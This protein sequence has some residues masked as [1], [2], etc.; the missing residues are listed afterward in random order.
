[1]VFKACIICTSPPLT[2]THTLND[3]LF[4]SDLLSTPPLTHRGLDASPACFE[5][6]PTLRHLHCLLPLPRPP[7]PHVSTWLTPPLP[8]DFCSVVT[9]SLRLSQT[10]L[11]HTIISL[12]HATRLLT[13]WPCSMTF[14]YINHFLTCHILY[15][16]IM[17]IHNQCLPQLEYQP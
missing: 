1:M 16:L 6:T 17:F 5:L 4:P 8:S 7:F 13:P 14:F 15:L 3:C 9:F 10:T 12:H 11:C 2:H